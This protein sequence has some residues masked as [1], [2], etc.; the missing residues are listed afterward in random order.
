LQRWLP[1]K[2]HWPE[3]QRL[4]GGSSLANAFQQAGT[5]H[6]VGDVSAGVFCPLV[7]MKFK[8]DIFFICTTSHT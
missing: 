7:L 5:H 8:K 6:L 3:T 4:L 2:N 1:S